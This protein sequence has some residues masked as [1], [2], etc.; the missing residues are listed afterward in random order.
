MTHTAFI[1]HFYYEQ[2]KQCF[3]DSGG[4]GTAEMMISLLE[5]LVLSQRE[6]GWCSSIELQI[7][8][9]NF[10]EFF[11]EDRIKKQKRK[12]KKK[13][14]INMKHVNI[15]INIP[16]NKGD[17]NSEYNVPAGKCETDYFIGE[18]K[19]GKSIIIRVV[20]EYIIGEWKNVNKVYAQ[21]FDNTAI[22]VPTSRTDVPEDIKF[23][24]DLLN[25]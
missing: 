1:S 22:H 4:Q 24:E 7:S 13:N 9:E 17:W 19:E 16:G 18:Y 10:L 6:W 25:G 3:G 23:F 8:L 12:T 21:V 14:K 2:L 5:L 11:R 20:S 15:S